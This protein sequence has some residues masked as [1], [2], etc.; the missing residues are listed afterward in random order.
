M[1]DA[2]RR[3]IST[4]LAVCAAGVLLAATSAS[5]DWLVTKDGARVETRGAWKIDGNR[6]VFT[7]PNGTLSMLRLAEVDLDRS[8]VATA[9]A[10]QPAAAPAA[11]AVKPK[12]PVLVLTEK[13]LPPVGEAVDEEEGEKPPE[14]QKADDSSGL[15]VVSWEKTQNPSKDGVEIYGTIKNSGR[16]VITA[17]SLMVI[18]YGPDGGLLATSDA[19]INAGAITPGASANFRVEFPGVGDF[20]SIKFDIRGRGFKANEAENGEEGG[21]PAEPN[22]AA[23]EGS[24][25]APPPDDGGG[26][27]PPGF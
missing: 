12:P 1:T 3:F 20:G 16:N 7:L 17:P 2:R 27:P 24:E 14:T 18:I 11:P 23:A 21:T 5:A 15:E 26:E 9:A 19:S 4:T 22:P 6:V 13:D 8:A 25:E 10:K